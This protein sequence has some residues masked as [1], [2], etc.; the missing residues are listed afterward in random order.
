MVFGPAGMA[1]QQPVGLVS[2]LIGKEGGIA[3][4]RLCV[5]MERK[6]MS[7]VAGFVRDGYYGISIEHVVPCVFCID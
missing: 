5:R 7:S 4:G 1:A 2:L 3:T 6:G